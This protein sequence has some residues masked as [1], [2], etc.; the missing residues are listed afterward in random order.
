[1][2]GMQQAGFRGTSTS[3]NSIRKKKNKEEKSE[4]IGNFIHALLVI[5][6]SIYKLHSN[7]KILGIFG[8]NKIVHIV[9]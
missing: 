5:Y 8:H 2:L 9:P 1:M 7:R 4:V 3:N 6:I